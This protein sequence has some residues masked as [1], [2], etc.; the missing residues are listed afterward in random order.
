MHVDY[1]VYSVCTA[2][3]VSVTREEYFGGHTHGVVERLA[4]ARYVTL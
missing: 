4:P 2:V 3:Q 1:T